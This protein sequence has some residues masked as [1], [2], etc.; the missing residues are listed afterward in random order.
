MP[1]L[2]FLLDADMPRS[3][4]KLIRSLGYDVEDVRD[5]GL[6]AIFIVCVL[7]A[8]I[9]AAT[10]FYPRWLSVLGVNASSA[11]VQFWTLAIPVFIA[12]IAVMAI[13]AWIGWTM[14]TTLPPKPIEEIEAETKSEAEE[15]TDACTER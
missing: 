14:A 11:T 3:S 2:K 1:S 15:K 7:V 5:I 6:R 10:L 8:V 13:G 9:Y 12:F 4:A